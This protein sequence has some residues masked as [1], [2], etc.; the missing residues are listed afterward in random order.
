[1][2]LLK[3]I[4]RFESFLLCNRIQVHLLLL[5]ASSVFQTVQK[6]YSENKRLRSIDIEFDNQI[7]FLHLFST[8]LMEHEQHSYL[9]LVLSISFVN[10]LQV[11]PNHT[12]GYAMFAN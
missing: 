1:M 2:H 11:I 7:T 3:A 10:G 5:S 9:Q 12:V 4:Y 6:K 8:L